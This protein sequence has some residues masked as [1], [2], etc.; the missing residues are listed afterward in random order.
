[1]VFQ[2]GSKFFKNEQ[3][4][5]E[6][7]E[8]EVQ[9][10]LIQL[11]EVQNKDDSLLLKSIDARLAALEASRDLSQNFFHIDMYVSWMLPQPLH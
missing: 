10:M 2:Q 6:R 7:V 3:M 5:S 11:R 4:K 9:R 1:V 8:R